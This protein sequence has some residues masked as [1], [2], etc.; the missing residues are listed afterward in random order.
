MFPQ[1]SP[2]FSLLFRLSQA[3]QR[4]YL[5]NLSLLTLV[6]PYTG[7]QFIKV[8]SSIRP[9]VFCQITV[10]LSLFIHDVAKIHSCKKKNN[11]FAG[12]KSYQGNTHACIHSYT[13]TRTDTLFCTLV[14][15]HSHRKHTLPNIHIH[16]C[17]YIR[18]YVCTYV[19]V[20]VSCLDVCAC[21]CACVLT[22]KTCT[23]CS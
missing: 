8:M 10:P 14:H 20:F 23:S 1:S 13:H 17:T 9:V 5:F 11:F 15:N 4:H 12:V 18:K 7:H 2:V 21:V 3:S 16:T 22:C 6:W 19:S